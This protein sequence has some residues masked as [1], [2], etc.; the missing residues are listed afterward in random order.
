MPYGHTQSLVSA[1]NVPSLV[2][3]TSIRRFRERCTPGK[4]RSDIR[5]F[6]AADDRYATHFQDSK[7]SGE[8]PRRPPAGSSRVIEP[9][10][11][12]LHRRTVLRFGHKC[13]QFGDH[14]ES[15]WLQ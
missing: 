14:D 7:V 15:P 2:I 9:E 10:V 6:I 11:H 3:M 8:I 13:S 12:A 1:T 4:E 5:L